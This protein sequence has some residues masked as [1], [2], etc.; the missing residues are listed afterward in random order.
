MYAASKL[1]IH[2][3][4]LHQQAHKLDVDLDSTTAIAVA[5]DDHHAKV[6]ELFQ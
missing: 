2:L 1:R 6:V 3:V 5:L 4:C